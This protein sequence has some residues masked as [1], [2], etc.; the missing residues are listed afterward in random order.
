MGTD[1]FRNIGRSDIYIIS[2]SQDDMF[3]DIL[4][5]V[6]PAEEKDIHSRETGGMRLVS[7]SCITHSVLQQQYHQTESPRTP[8]APNERLGVR[9][10]AR[11]VLAPP[12]SQA[13]SERMFATVGLIVTPVRNSLSSENVELLVYLRNVW[14]VAEKWKISGQ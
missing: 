1:V 2:R 6:F 12:S 14:G 4:G 11:R 8:V 13:Q 10:L 3:A 7:T 5:N 9:G